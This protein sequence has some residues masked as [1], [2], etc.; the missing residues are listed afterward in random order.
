M[1]VRGEDLKRSMSQYLSDQIAL[2]PAIRV[3]TETQ[4]VSADGTDC[5]ANEATPYHFAIS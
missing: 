5:I 4:V 1:Q 3:E 2:V